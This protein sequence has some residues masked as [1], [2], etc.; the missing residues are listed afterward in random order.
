MIMTGS[1]AV[2]SDGQKTV[3]GFRC[4]TRPRFIIK[5]QTE[6]QDLKAGGWLVRDHERLRCFFPPCILPSPLPHFPLPIL[7][8]PQPTQ[9]KHP[10]IVNNAPPHPPILPLPPP[11]PPSCSPFSL[12]PPSPLSAPPP[13]LPPHKIQKRALQAFPFFVS[14]VRNECR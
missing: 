6:P 14:D 4:S 12:P 10:R 11:S 1:I 13:L 8:H 7:P 5:L 9:H 2:E 3:D